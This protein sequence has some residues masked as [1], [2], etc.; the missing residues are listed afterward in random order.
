MIRENRWLLALIVILLAALVAI[1]L[2]A[3]KTT[4]SRNMPDIL[5]H[6]VRSIPP[7]PGWKLI[8]TEASNKGSAAGF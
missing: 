5:E 1:N 6:E 2:L 4:S 8:D 7:P 3:P